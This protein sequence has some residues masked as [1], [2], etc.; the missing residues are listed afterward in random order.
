[1]IIQAADAARALIDRDAGAAGGDGHGL[2]VLGCSRHGRHRRAG[3]GRCPDYQS[4]VSWEL[5]L[6]ALARGCPAA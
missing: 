2:Q 1:M 3:A 6:R 4:A 5:F